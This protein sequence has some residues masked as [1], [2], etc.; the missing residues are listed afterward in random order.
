VDHDTVDAI[1]ELGQKPAFQLT[2]DFRHDLGRFDRA[3][4]KADRARELAEAR[5]SSRPFGGHG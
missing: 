4:T 2:I 1:A 3:R 5:A